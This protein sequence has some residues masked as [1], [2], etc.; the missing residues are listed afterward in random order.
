VSPADHHGADDDL[1]EDAEVS[2]QRR[3]VG[4]VAE[5]EAHVGVRGH[6]FEE[7]GEDGEGLV[8]SQM[9]RRWWCGVVWDG[10]VRAGNVLTGSLTSMM[11]L[12]SAAQMQ[13]T[14]RNT[15]HRS[16]LNWLRMW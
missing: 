2:A 6:H 7:D 16:K 1:A 9:V 10:C 14:P 8:A 12:L 11:R 4:R 5:R 3:R 15:Y 13:K